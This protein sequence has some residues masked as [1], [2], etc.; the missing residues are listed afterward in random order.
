MV[1]NFIADKKLKELVTSEDEKK[2]KKIL[3]EYESQGYSKNFEFKYNLIAKKMDE[4]RRV[5]S[6][7]WKDKI[8]LQYVNYMIKTCCSTQIKA[9]S[10]NNIIK[11]IQDNSS[12]YK[13]LKVTDMSKYFDCIDREL[14]LKRLKLKVGDEKISRNIENALINVFKA[15]D[16]SNNI[17]LENEFSSKSNEI[18]SGITIGVGI[19]QGIPISNILSI[20]YLDHLELKNSKVYRY[21]D[22][23]FILSNNKSFNDIKKELK[24]N[25]LKINNSKTKYVNLITGEIFDNFGRKQKIKNF[26]ILGYETQIKNQKLTTSPSYKS[27]NRQFRLLNEI[28]KEYEISPARKTYLE[29]KLNLQIC[30]HINEQKQMGWV[31]YYQS[32]NDISKL[33]ILDNW[34][35]RNFPDFNGKKKYIR[36]YHSIRN[37][38][39][40]NDKSAKK[41]MCYITAATSINKINISEK[42]QILDSYYG[43]EHDI[44]D[45]QVEKRF[46]KIYYNDIARL[47]EDFGRK[48]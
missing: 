29:Y 16:K 2:I 27:F 6:V 20:I 9:T 8:I 34:V 1:E 33:K 28:K 26:N 42:R 45:S 18:R 31:H 14:L 40:K 32:I 24:L 39:D 4:C 10:C 46:E 21:I 47:E 15:M 13:Y 5:F 3:C 11:Q 7:D 35:E 17:I 44:P 41:N 25:A 43:S 23:I 48:S 22:D 12:K 38:N 37:L 19:P 30:G 36:T